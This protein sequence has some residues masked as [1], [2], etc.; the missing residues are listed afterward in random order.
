MIPHGDNFLNPKKSYLMAI[1]PLLRLNEGLLSKARDGVADRDFTAIGWPPSSKNAQYGCLAK[2][3]P[4]R[5][6]GR[7]SLFLV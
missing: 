2:F 5:Q 7:S 6:L 4:E 1:F 3:L